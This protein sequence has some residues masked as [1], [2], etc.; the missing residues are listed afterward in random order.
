MNRF[1]RLQIGM[2]DT[3]MKRFLWREIRVGKS[4][5][6]RLDPKLWWVLLGSSVPLIQ[7]LACRLLVQPCSF[8]CCERNW[9]T[10]SFIHSA[11]KETSRNQKEQKTC[12]MCMLICNS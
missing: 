12:F 3:R 4:Y 8:S 10:Y 6:W 7:R 5:V 9:S 1:K 11:K 2:F